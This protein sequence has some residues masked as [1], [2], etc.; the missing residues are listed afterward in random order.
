MKNTDRPSPTSE[1]VNQPQPQAEQYGLD[2]IALFI[3]HTRESYEKKYGRQARPFDPN[4][5][6]QTFFDTS[7]PGFDQSYLK[8]TPQGLEEFTLTAEERATPNLPGRYRY[9]KPH[10]PETRA[11]Q[12]NPDGRSE[13]I[14]P[15]LLTT[16]AEAS[17]LATE[18]SGE[19]HEDRN[20]VYPYIYPEGEDRRVHFITGP[21]FNAFAW[22]LRQLQSTWGVGAPGEWEIGN[23]GNVDLRKGELQWISSPIPDGSGVR[24]FT[25]VPVRA[26][27]ANETVV[28]LQ[29]GLAAI[30][31]TE[32]VP[33]AG[34]NSADR[35]KLD[36]IYRKLIADG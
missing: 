29:S 32:V 8:L 3:Q 7:T 20:P 27:L 36:A 13:P 5:I 24:D 25:P 16:A 34:F 15:Y 26:L 6:I 10:Y 28:M 23:G 17:S 4:R 31:R 14:A 12:Q 21:G 19:Y 30:R 35:K 18:L 11:Y 2:A 33:A 1:P 9:P 22:L